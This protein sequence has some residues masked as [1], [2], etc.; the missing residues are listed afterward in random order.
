MSLTTHPDFITAVK[1]AKAIAL[2]TS[3]RE[4][5]PYLLLAGFFTILDRKMDLTESALRLR[6]A[7]LRDACVRLEIPAE[8]PL[9]KAAEIRFP[10]SNRLRQLVKES[11]TTVE[12]LVDQLLESSKPDEADD[13]LFELVRAKASAHSRRC[14]ASA[15]SADALSAAALFAFRDGVFIEHP[16]VAAHI[17]LAASNIE[18]V[19]DLNKWGSDSFI[20]DRGPAVGIEGSL[21]EKLD[22]FD[23]AKIFAVIDLGALSG[24]R[25]A[26]Q[27]ST[28]FHEAGHAVVSFMLRPQVPITQVSVV[29]ASGSEGRTGFDANSPYVTGPVSRRHF[30]E[31][32]QIL[33]AGG[34]AE[35]I[36][37]GD[38]FLDEGALS[39]I[40]R[41]SVAAWDWVAKYGLDDSF[42]PISLPALV[43]QP[44]Y[45]A[46][47]LSNEAQRLVQQVLKTGRE[48]AKNLLKGNWHHVESLAGLLMERK[49]LNTQEVVEA[50]I[51]KGIAAWPGTQKVRSKSMD[52]EV[53]F[54]ESSGVCQ[55]MEGPVRYVAGDAV[56]TGSQSEE[57]PI[58][59]AK[60]E[61]AYQPIGTTTIG[62]AGTYRKT[63]R[64]GIAIQLTAPRSVVLNDGRGVLQGRAGDWVIDYGGG[65]LSLVS[66]S[67]FGLYYEILI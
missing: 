44:G 50:L 28:A 32:L 56:V 36:K 25:L 22:E 27:R 40:E 43:E 14:G 23:I 33:L 13:T 11:S 45:A 67:L 38:D 62:S 46:G 17:A 54:A 65:D 19:I 47:F 7:A 16:A 51:D 18:Y 5:T 24:E 57:W 9:E 21:I 53:R 41:A 15:L 8:L 37:F 39:D 1:V 58:S 64:D 6:E 52:R 63:P 48:D 26:R 10:L 31:Y 3:K 29:G 34:I 61:Q 59:R 12:S 35:Q 55:T 66:A 30:R 60:F 42:G 20:D 4:L 49:T 2:S